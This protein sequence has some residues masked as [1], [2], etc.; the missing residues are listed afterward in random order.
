[1]APITASELVPILAVIALLIISVSAILRRNGNGYSAPPSTQ[2]SQ[3]KQTGQVEQAEQAER[4]LRRVMEIAEE[5][6]GLAE[7][8]RE[9]ANQRGEQLR[10]I[11]ITPD[12]QAAATTLTRL[13]TDLRRLF[14]EDEIDQLAFEIG[15]NPDELAGE[16]IVERSRNLVLMM[17]RRNKLGALV[18]A[19]RA[20]RPEAKWE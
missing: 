14:S 7:M 8:W 2:S 10:R 15:V 13:A 16:G 12:T 1:M 18:A 3:S 6:R 20:A 11:G 9:V 19:M 4:E 17:D 5:Y